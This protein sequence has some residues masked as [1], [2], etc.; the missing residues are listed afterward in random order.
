MDWSELPNI[1]YKK[2]KTR[3]SDLISGEGES[4]TYEY[5]F[6]DSWNHDILLE[7]ILPVDTTAKFPVCLDGKRN[8]PPEDCGGVWGYTQLLEI[9][10]N[11]EH[12]EYKSYMDW[13]GGKFDPDYFNIDRVNAILQRLRLF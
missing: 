6:G 1:D 7:K 8:G 3:V 4:L 5:D 11:P 2:E 10:N 12:E 13:L 9:L